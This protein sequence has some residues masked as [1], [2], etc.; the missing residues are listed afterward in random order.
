MSRIRKLSFAV[1][2]CVVV[3]LLA[4]VT[5]R[6]LETTADSVKDH[7]AGFSAFSPVFEV[8]AGS[9]D[10]W[11]RTSERKLEWFNP[12][13]FPCRKPSGT[14]RV[15]C[16]GGST[17]YGRP[18]DDR[19]SFCGWLR[20]FLTELDQKTQW[21][22]I[23]AGGI[24]YGS[25]RVLGVLKEI[26]QYEP[27]VV[28]VYCGHNEF[29]ERTTYSRISSLPTAVVWLGDIL[30]EYSALCRS[31]SRLTARP[32]SSTSGTHGNDED[33]TALL[34]SSVGLAAYHHDDEWHDEVVSAYE[35][36]IQQ[37]IDVAGAN[38]VF[39]APAAELRDCRPFK[40]EHT[41]GLSLAR[42]STAESIFTSAMAA[43]DANDWNLAVEHCKELVDIDPEF[44]AGHYLHG[45]SLYELGEYTESRQALEAARD[46]DICPLRATAQI[47]SSLAAVTGRN[48]RDLL[49]FR[50]LVNQQSEHGIPGADT[51][52]DHVHP[53]I[54]GNRRLAIRLVEWL[55]SV[56]TTDIDVHAA[57]P[58]ITAVTKRLTESI[59]SQQHA[60]ALRNLSK[61]LSW[62]GK[63][64]EADR[65]AI[66]AMKMLPDDS[67][68]QYQAGSAFYRLG[69]LQN[70]AKAYESASQLD[71]LF[72]PAWFGLGLVHTENEE[73]PAA[74][75]NYKR[76]SELKPGFLDIEFNLGRAYELSGD[77]SSAA[78]Q[79]EVCIRLD[80]LF[81]P[82][83]N[84]MGTV[85]ARQGDLDSATQWFR[86]ALVADPDDQNA[87]I[88]LQM[89]LSQQSP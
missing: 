12:Q 86:R 60:A 41:D 59:D 48:Q 63:Y 88:N 57:G 2:T 64:E 32:R 61:V 17:T 7:M 16:L 34:D 30:R 49:D 36:N 82:A 47:H 26:I 58:G 28:I 42:Q 29:L 38:I 67:E 68:S 45:I 50:E 51:F 3:L 62:A 87:K 21:E 76:A 66:R 53:T 78:R 54:D 83:Y 70:A 27:D 81:A 71:P 33:V 31:V 25:L 85:N 69:D 40:S 46:L 77:L 1:C 6:L 15:F 84:G 72:A 10:C 22:V 56:G 74:I 35:R 20:E 11:M 65:L 9:A 5:L 75:H 18:Y 8:D 4:E 13:R 89:A 39:V 73:W 24:S 23:N 19:T 52:L 80:D 43:A 79:Y 14:K 55:S 37:M 44:A